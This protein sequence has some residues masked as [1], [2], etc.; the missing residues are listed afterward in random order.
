MKTIKTKNL[1][2]IDFDG[3]LKYRC[4]KCSCDHWISFKQARIEHFKV[5]C[6]CDTVFE[7]KPVEKIKLIYSTIELSDQTSHVINKN[8]TA[9]DKNEIPTELLSKC[10]KILVGYG[11]TE[12]EAKSML[13]KAY[14]AYPVD[15][16]AM[17][18]KISIGST[19]EKTND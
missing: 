16:C 19:L 8:T 12:D 4:P 2:P 1:K 10:N 9:I 6:D 18:I 5:V 11:F 13:V 17:L 14:T 15:D 3:H 7:V